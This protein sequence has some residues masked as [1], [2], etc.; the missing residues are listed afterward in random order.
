MSSIIAVIG[1]RSFNDRKLAFFILDKY[2]GDRGGHCIITGGA[3]GADALAEEWAISRG[4]PVRIL[5]AEWGKYGRSA[6]PRR[7]MEIVKQCQGMIAFWDGKSPGTKD[8][9]QKAWAQGKKV[10]II[11]T[12]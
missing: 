6:G 7:N 2:V 3:H 5:P 4:V 9:I 8:S 10:I 12:T 11:H 1:S